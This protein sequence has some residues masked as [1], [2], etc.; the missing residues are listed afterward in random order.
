M[1]LEFTGRNIEVTEALKEFTRDKLEK[2]LRLIN[3]TGEVQVIFSVE[4]HRH[5]VEYKV[6]S[7]S[8]N[9]NCKDESQDLYNSIHAASEIL[10]KL[11]KKQKSKIWGK[12]RRKARGRN[13]LNMQVFSIEPGEEGEKGVPRIIKSDNFVLKPMSIEEAALQVENSKNEFL[14][15]RNSDSDKISVVY[16]RKDGNYGLIEPDFS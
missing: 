13:N 12:K 4:K 5:C 6:T 7:P 1:N 16:K 2:S 3:E 11:I 8:Y 15:F 14:V 10:E 9:I